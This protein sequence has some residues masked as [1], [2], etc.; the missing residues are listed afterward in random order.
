MLSYACSITCHDLQKLA[1]LLFGYLMIVQQPVICT[2]ID[3][4]Y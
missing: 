4:A 1:S 2:E 3:V